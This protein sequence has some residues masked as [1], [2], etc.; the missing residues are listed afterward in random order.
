MTMMM[1]K[2]MMMMTTMTIIIIV[3]MTIIIVVVVHY[4]YGYHINIMTYNTLDY[5]LYYDNLFINT[6]HI[7][8]SRLVYNIMHTSHKLGCNVSLS[9]S[10]TYN[11][12]YYI[13]ILGCVCHYISLYCCYIIKIL[14][15]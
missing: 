3:M 13:L 10:P 6:S 15:N 9:L 7:L 14:L 8:F 5:T 4:C 11:N 1:M 12:H 2:M